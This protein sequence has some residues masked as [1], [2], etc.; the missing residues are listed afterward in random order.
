MESHKKPQNLKVEYFIE[1]YWDIILGIIATAIAFYLHFHGFVATAIIFEAIAIIFFSVTIS[2]IA[3]ILA[4][5][6]TEP[7]GSLLL[8][9]TA[10]AVEIL[11][12]F[13]IILEA[14]TSPEAAQTVK[15]GIISAVIVDMN[16]LLGLSVLIGGLAFKQQEH[17]EETSGSYT[18]ILLVTSCVLLV[19]SVLKFQT[20]DATALLKVSQIIAVLL[21]AYYAVILVFQIKTHSS[22]FK[23]TARSRL[24]RYKKRM[25][26][27]NDEDDYIHYIFEKLPT[28]FNFIAMLALIA[29]VGL[30]AELLAKDGMKEAAEIGITPGLSGLI[31]AFIAVAPEFLTAIRAAKNDEP[32]RVINIAMGASAATILLTVPFII[33][34]AE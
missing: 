27:D 9:F 14:P 23:A 26:E 11:L 1:D 18:T 19:P 24:L 16:L 22:F 10:V 3:E 8:T 28:I 7:Y 34:L 20:D 15:G 13:M 29:A 21:F 17:N 6:V 33:L 4:E 31:I 12:L 2:E 25:Q 32:Q 30:L 5:R